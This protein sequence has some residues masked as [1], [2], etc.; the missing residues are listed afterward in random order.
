MNLGFNKI[1]RNSHFMLS[2]SCP[3][4]NRGSA[5]DFFGKGRRNRRFG[6]GWCSWKVLFCFFLYM[7][8]FYCLHIQEIRA[9]IAFRL[10]TFDYIFDLIVSGR[11]YTLIFQLAIICSVGSSSS[12]SNGSNSIKS[13]VTISMGVIS[14]LPGSAKE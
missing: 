14:K 4:K 12:R 1:V 2:G 11:L 9:V 13:M 10:Y 3:T 8:N 7:W 5:E 6:Y